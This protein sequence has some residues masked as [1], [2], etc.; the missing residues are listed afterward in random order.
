MI[1]ITNILGGHCGVWVLPFSLNYIATQ[2]SEE[3][4]LVSLPFRRVPKSPA[5]KMYQMN[6]HKTVTTC[7]ALNCVLKKFLAEAFNPY[8]TIGDRTF[9][10]VIKVRE[11]M[12]F[13]KP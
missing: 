1:S 5:H 13:L 4:C 3:C 8:M 9:R 6:V 12:R 11:F 2:P 7:C 10:E